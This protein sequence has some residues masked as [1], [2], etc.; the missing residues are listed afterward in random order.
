MFPPGKHESK[1]KVFELIKDSD[2]EFW[3][4]CNG[5]YD[6][7]ETCNMFANGA[8]INLMYDVILMD[9]AIIFCA[10]S[11]VI[12]SLFVRHLR[13]KHLSMVKI[14]DNNEGDGAA[15]ILVVRPG[16]IRRTAALCVTK[17]TIQYLDLPCNHV[18]LTIPVD[19]CDTNSMEKIKQRLSAFCR[20][21]VDDDRM[22]FCDVSN[23]LDLEYINF[24]QFSECI[25]PF[26]LKAV[27]YFN[28]NYNGLRCIAII[29][30]NYSI[31]K[32]SIIFDGF[33]KARE[34]SEKD[35]NILS[36]G[37]FKVIK[38]D[39]ILDEFLN[40]M[41][42]ESRNVETNGIYDMNGR[43]FKSLFPREWL[44]C[45]IIDIYLNKWREQ[46]KKTNCNPFISKYKIKM[47]DT[48]LFTRL[49][50]GVRFNFSS[51][52]IDN[53]SFDCLHENA[54][55]IANEKIY[56]PSSMFSTIF[57]FDLLVIPINISDHWVAGIIHKPGNCL[58][59]VKKENG[60]WTDIGDFHSSI[61]IYDSLT[62][63][64]IFNK[65]LCCM[66][67]KKYMEACYGKINQGTLDKEMLFDEEK[68]RFIDIKDP[69]QQR[70]GYD[71]GFFM[72]EFIR[73]VLIDP[74][75]V[76]KLIEGQ[77]MK[78]VFPNFEVKCGREYLKSFVYSK[79][80][81]SKWIILYEMEQFFLVNQ[82]GVKFKTLRSRSTEYMRDK[83]KLKI[84]RRSKSSNN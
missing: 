41:V 34:S 24:S 58:Q 31:Y 19:N 38:N 82:Y 47:Y 29:R 51:G 63:D 48:F 72:L 25:R 26:D 80:D 73:Q 74:K 75:I 16:A 49:T 9:D 70:N 71:C 68:I 42:C 17:E 84:Q 55:R 10:K 11:Y 3:E 56:K 33:L 2:K 40:K 52:T 32:S 28:S 53:S 36:T 14:L 30:D 67:L 12:K 60:D 6:V 43:A 57:D 78:D 18:I 15:I 50:R 44:H 76:V 65:Q 69:Y 45:D 23:L 54:A 39:D 81:I 1:V 77:S 8:E 61:L 46:K 64:L 22:V 13:R 5:N 59:K 37:N 66:V 20:I 7:V 62:K 21:S 27:C 4:Q 79:I 83:N 35:T